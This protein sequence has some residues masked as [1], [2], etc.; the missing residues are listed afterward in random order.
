MLPL[1]SG[2]GFS[3]RGGSRR[4]ESDL[5]ARKIAGH[6]LAGT[7]RT[8]EDPRAMNDRRHPIWREYLEALLVAGLFLGFTN[9]FVLKT[10]YIPSGSMEDTLLIGDHLIVNRYVYGT[11]AGRAGF[12]PNSMKAV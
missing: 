10:F 3:R 1:F 12:G 7:R 2:G 4:V 5:D 11:G 6:R 9:T 8:G